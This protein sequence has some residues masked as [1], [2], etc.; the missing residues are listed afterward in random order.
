ML[1]SIPILGTEPA[2]ENRIRSFCGSTPG[3]RFYCKPVTL[4]R[5]RDYG[6]RSK[7]NAIRSRVPKGCDRKAAHKSGEKIVSLVGLAESCCV[8]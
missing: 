8:R 1:N 5:C 2:S 3:V 7:R 6:L 4:V